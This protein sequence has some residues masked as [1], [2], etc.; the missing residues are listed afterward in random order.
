MINKTVLGS[1]YLVDFDRQEVYRASTDSDDIIHH[2]G[3]DGKTWTFLCVEP[4]EEFAARIRR[5][6]ANLPSKLI[7]CR[8]E[9]YLILKEKYSSSWGW[10]EAIYISGTTQG[11]L[12]T[13]I[14][15]GRYKPWSGWAHFPW[16]SFSLKRD[17]EYYDLVEI[18]NVPK[19]VPPL[20]EKK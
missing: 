7:A 15:K 8:H 13:R 6:H 20:P 18:G 16:N 4:W 5:E 17:A 1:K 11:N 3:Q 2:R 9:S 19:W 12:K 14:W 10:N